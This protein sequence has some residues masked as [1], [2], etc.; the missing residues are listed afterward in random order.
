VLGESHHPERITTKPDA[1]NVCI[2]GLFQQRCR[3]LDITSVYS[4]PHE[5]EDN[6][7]S[8]RTFRDIGDLAHTMMATDVFP[9]TGWTNYA[10]LDDDTPYYRIFGENYDMSSVRIFGCHDFVHIPSAQRTPYEPRAAE[11]VYVGHDDASP[12]YQIYSPA[13]DR[14]K[15]VGTPNFIK[16]VRGHLCLSP[17]R[18]RLRLCFSC[19]SH[20]SFLQQ[21][22]SLAR[23]RQSEDNL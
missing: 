15:V 21:A 4:H 18:L 12:A 7:S 19:G 9:S 16:D 14:T 17:D 2:R 1:D 8:E 23:H 11:G 10:E 20:Q 3:R 6:G 22:C 5:H 13:T